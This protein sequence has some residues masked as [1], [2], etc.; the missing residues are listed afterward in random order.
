MK[1]WTLIFSTF[2]GGRVYKYWTIAGALQDLT[3]RHD[4]EKCFVDLE[5]DKLNLSIRLYVPDKQYDW[6]KGLNK[7]KKYL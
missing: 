4:Y 2:D 1:N 5:N 7:P 6:T 3:T